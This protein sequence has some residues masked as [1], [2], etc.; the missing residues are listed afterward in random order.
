[1]NYMNIIKEKGG[2]DYGMGD[3]LGEMAGESFCRVLVEIMENGA[4]LT[5]VLAVLLGAAGLAAWPLRAVLDD[6]GVFDSVSSSGM[7]GQYVLRTCLSAGRRMGFE[8]KKSMPESRHS[9]VYVSRCF[10]IV[11]NARTYFYVALLSIRSQSYNR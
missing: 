11:G 3:V 6:G 2:R 10:Q 5:V 9:C 8:R 1:M 4:A 7:V